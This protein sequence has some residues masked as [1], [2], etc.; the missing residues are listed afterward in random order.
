MIVSGAVQRA[1]GVSVQEF[2]REQL[3]WPTG[4]QGAPVVLVSER[5]P[6]LQRWV[7]S[8]SPGTWPS[9]GNWCLNKG[10]WQGKQIVSEDWLAESTRARFEVPSYGYGYGYLWWSTELHDKSGKSVDVFMAL[11][12]GGQH[13]FVVPERSLV[14]VITSGNYHP[15][16]VQGGPAG[17]RHAV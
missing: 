11:G 9:W 3:F 14:V 10:R 4:N 6:E 15:Q 8:H 5:S 1:V 7:T 2:A 17:D 16:D 13:L 12:Y